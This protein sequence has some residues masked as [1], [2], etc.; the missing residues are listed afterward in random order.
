MTMQRQSDASSRFR[1]MMSRRRRQVNNPL[2]RRL[3]S[4]ADLDVDR[5]HRNRLQIRVSWRID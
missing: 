2:S 3:Q 1:A 5:S 4:R